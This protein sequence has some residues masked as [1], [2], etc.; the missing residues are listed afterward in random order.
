MEPKAK[1]ASDFDLFNIFGG[2]K[3]NGKGHNGNNSNGHKG[4]VDAQASPTEDEVK[5]TMQKTVKK[6]GLLRGLNLSFSKPK[7]TVE[8][9]DFNVGKLSIPTLDGA[10][11]ETDVTYEIDAPFQYVNIWFDG[12]EMSYNV[13]E[14]P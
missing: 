4:R 5:S 9:L 10:L 11:K 7:E 6:N 12:E 3:M 2:F 8:L 14:P 1:S 13:L